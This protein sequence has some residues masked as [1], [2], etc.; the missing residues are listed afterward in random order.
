MDDYD[1][2]TAGWGTTTDEYD[3]Q[4]ITNGLRDTSITPTEELGGS[5]VWDDVQH[6]YP[7]T[8]PLTSAMESDDVET[9]SPAAHPPTS[10]LSSIKNAQLYTELGS[11]E[12]GNRIFTSVSVSDPRKETVKDV[13][14][15]YQITTMC[16]VSSLGAP[17]F[18]VRRRYQDFAWL[19]SVLAVE[20]PQCIISPPPEKYRMG[21]LT[22]NRF[23]DEFI[24]KRR[25]GLERFIRRIARH[26]L[27]QLNEHVKQFLTTPNLANIPDRDTLLDSLGDSILNAFSKLKNPDQRF[28][29][30]KETTEK[31]EE[32]LLAIEKVYQK[33]T[34]REMELQDDNT[35]FSKSIVDLA[36]IETGMAEQLN[37]FANTINQATELMKEKTYSDE[38]AFVTQ[39]REYVVY[40]QSVKNIL[41]LRDQKQI[42]Y[43]VLQ[44]YLQQ[45][46]EEQ[47]RLQDT[48]GATGLTSYIKG[49]YEEM[50]GVDM[51]QARQQKLLRLEKRID[52]L[53]VAVNETH[54]VSLLFSREVI[55]EF[56][57]FQTD[58]ATDMKEFLQQYAESQAEFYRKSATLWDDLVP[59]LEQLDVD[60]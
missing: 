2:R 32:N 17:T 52:E 56:N 60:D 4:L 27:L 55:R 19:H 28:I 16:G 51:E 48:R 42:D 43:E 1:Y 38:H 41:R 8:D 35:I 46:Q 29:D 31:L 34:K 22:G 9:E 14:I 12:T 7:Q 40:C 57:N 5:T 15:S 23:D 45:Q 26:P 39:L 6:S 36:S 53:Q 11:Q 20:Y 30:I 50:K 33:M 18:T 47:K 49:K 44:F 24:E 13:H 3:P 58:K 59:L 25:A 10:N 37:G 54:D 21:Y